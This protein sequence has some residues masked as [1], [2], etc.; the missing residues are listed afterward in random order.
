M[1]VPKRH[2]INIAKI[3]F[4][5]DKILMSNKCVDLQK[6]MDSFYELYDEASWAITFSG[7]NE[8]D[9]HV[10][11]LLVALYYYYEQLWLKNILIPKASLSEEPQQ[12]VSKEQLRKHKK[13][14]EDKKIQAART[15]DNKKYF[16][17]FIY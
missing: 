17:K 8:N 9:D 12:S 13:E 5:N 16:Q 1:R 10:N 6:E 15:E 4:D 2:L 7:V 14:V 3:L 11:A